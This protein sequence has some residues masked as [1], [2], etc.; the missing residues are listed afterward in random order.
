MCELFQG[1]LAILLV[2]FPGFSLSFRYC[3][4]NTVT[5]LYNTIRLRRPNNSLKKKKEK[6]CS[7]ALSAGNHIV[8]AFVDVKTFSTICRN[9]KL[10]RLYIHML[11]CYRTDREKKTKTF[12][13]GPHHRVFPSRQR[14]S[15]SLCSCG[16][17]I[18]G[19]KTSTCST[20]TVLSRFNS[21]GLLLVFHN[22]K[23]VDGYEN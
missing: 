8:A 4:G 23:M 10:L 2:E 7:T 12:T 18:D 14:N 22:E 15:S 5:V 3:G 1:R 20:P 13:I 16:H 9:V 17:E 21:F 11:H 19:I 6:D